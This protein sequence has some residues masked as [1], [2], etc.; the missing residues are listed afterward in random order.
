[1]LEH[2]ESTSLES[3]MEVQRT[4]NLELYK[5]F[6]DHGINTLLSPIFRLDLL[7]RG[8]GIYEGGHEAVDLASQP[9]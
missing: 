7:D 4:R 3:Y 6:F 8:R 9:S 2:P 5:L 1:M